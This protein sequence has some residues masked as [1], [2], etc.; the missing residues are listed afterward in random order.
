MNT[1]VSGAPALAPVASA[2][3]I[4]ANAGEIG[5]LTIVAA[6]GNI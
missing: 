3:T 4:G 6:R 2:P 1:L 5:G